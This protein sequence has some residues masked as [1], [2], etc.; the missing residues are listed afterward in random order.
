MGKQSDHYGKT[1]VLSTNKGLQ[2]EEAYSLF[3]DFK[4]AKSANSL[5]QLFGKRY[6]KQFKKELNKHLESIGVVY[7]YKEMKYVDKK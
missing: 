5:Y 2:K 1:I 3:R 4:D 6:S 7:S